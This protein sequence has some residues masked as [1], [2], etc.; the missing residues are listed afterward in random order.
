MK[1]YINEYKTI[2]TIISEDEKYITYRF[3]NGYS[4]CVEK[5]SFKNM[6]KHNNY[7]EI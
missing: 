7:K 2:I 6:I 4:N 5:E 3:E 1:K